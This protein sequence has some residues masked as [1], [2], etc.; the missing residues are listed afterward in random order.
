MNVPDGRQLSV[1][2]GRHLVA[3]MGF[4]I[5][6]VVAA[7]G[8]A[9]SQGN[10]EFLFYIAVMAILIG[11]IYWMHR[12]VGISAALLWCLSA[13]GLLHMAGGLVRVPCLLYTSPS[14]RDDT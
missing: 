4:T 11:A 14:P 13:W 2:G 10:R 7:C 12:R 1:A 3:V 8:L 5:V 9:W 6:Y